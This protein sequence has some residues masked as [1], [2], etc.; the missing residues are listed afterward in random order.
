VL[1]DVLDSNPLIVAAYAATAFACWY[2]G[3][4][5]RSREVDD[6]D[7]SE[8]ATFWYV[9]AVALALV[10]L[11]RLFGIADDFSS[12]M[13]R[14]AQ[15]EGWYLRRREFQVPVVI[16]VVVLWIVAIPFAWRAVRD[17]SRRVQLA[18]VVAVSLLCFSVIRVISLH[19]VDHLVYR[20]SVF[21][22]RVATWLELG[23]LA[24]LCALACIERA[25]RPVATP[26]D[27]S[28]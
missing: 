18:A 8:W 5:A 21:G 15:D 11:V 2:A 24:A 14:K 10:G 6:D 16:A 4:R 19:Q 26:A 13:H 23:A 3:G 27:R 20:E 12:F 17:R 28:A 1:G 22:V 25:R 7:D 9:I